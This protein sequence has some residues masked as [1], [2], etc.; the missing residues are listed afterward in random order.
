[1]PRSRAPR[2]RSRYA[3]YV[4]LVLVPVVVLAFMLP[5]LAAGTEVA[6]DDDLCPVDA[7]AITDRA[8][9]LLDFRKPLGTHTGLPADLLRTV[10]LGLAAGTELRVF[11][12]AADP[13]TPRVLVDRVCK[14]YAN[15][16]LA[17]STAKDQRSEMRDCDDPPAQLARSARERVAQF[18]ERRDVLQRR[19]R[20]LA[21]RRYETT[22]ASAYVIEAIEDTRL[23]LV[24]AQRPS[25]YVFSDMMQH[26]EWY[27]HAQLGPDRWTHDDLAAAREQRGGLLLEQPTQDPDLSVTIF[28]APRRGLTESPRIARMH[29][30]FWSDYFS[31]AGAVTFADQPTLP[32]YDVQPI[33]AV[34]HDAEVAAEEERLRQERERNERERQELEAQKAEL[35]KAR[36]E[37]AAEARQ[38]AEQE[39]EEARRRAAREAEE[40]RQREEREAE[41]R[42]REQRIAELAARAEEQS[43]TAE[44]DGPDDDR[45]AESQTPQAQ[46]G[47]RVADDVGPADS[48]PPA[49]PQ[50]APSS[51]PTEPSTSVADSE[52]TPTVDQPLCVTRPKSRRDD[53]Y[54]RGHRVNYGS[55]EIVVRFTIDEQGQTEDNGI[56]VVEDESTAT[57]PRFFDLFVD[58]AV[59]EIKDWEFDFVEVDGGCR[60]RQEVATKLVF[61]F[62][63]R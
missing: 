18:C 54:P 48:P 6:L 10:T 20:N 55:A 27:S 22:V 1:M 25:L 13:L 34:P 30:R 26:A 57:R 4:A 47:E 38:R 45:P 44:G 51:Q 5:F 29:K 32:A 59:E 12:L 60:R 8:V 49:E 63:G 7:N 28:Y 50:P 53:I 56:I 16:D 31:R 2:G 23:D 40:A 21:A 17:V 37:A 19:I 33:L 3:L 42:A 61:R 41:L 62:R 24:A 46:A 39:A 52:P 15:A 58:N 9:L 43:A 35:E 36:E 14:P 11:T